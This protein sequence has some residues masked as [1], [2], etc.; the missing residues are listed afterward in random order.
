MTRP[1][2]RPPAPP[3]TSRHSKK[4]DGEGDDD[5]VLGQA[6]QQ[7]VA[8][9][10]DAVRKMEEETAVTIVERIQH[11]RRPDPPD[12]VQAEQMQ[13]A[14][15]LREEVPERLLEEVCLPDGRDELRV[16]PLE[17]LLGRER[18]DPV[19]Y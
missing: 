10:L 1:E 7:L 8:A 17:L 16:A 13:L 19:S 11:R 6:D 14:G 9:L 12:A 15:V 18:D 3:V 2:G 4:S 5:L